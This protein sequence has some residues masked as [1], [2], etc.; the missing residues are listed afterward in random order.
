MYCV[1]T[2]LEL[3]ELRRIVDQFD[4]S[5]FITVSD[6]SE[7][8]GEHMKKMRFRRK[9]RKRRRKTIKRRVQN[10]STPMKMH[11]KCLTQEKTYAI[12]ALLQQKRF[13]FAAICKV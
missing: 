8:I 9:K 6:I 12:M 13:Q 7:I 1:I 3:I 11:K 4:G 5:A 10:K 2:R